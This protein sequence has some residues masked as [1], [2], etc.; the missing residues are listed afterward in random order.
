[1]RRRPRR[2]LGRGR[3]DLSPERREGRSRGEA[4]RGHGRVSGGAGRR[5]R[6]RAGDRP[7]ARGE[8][9][10]RSRGRRDGDASFRGNP[11]DRCYHC[12]TAILSKL[13]AIAQALGFPCI[14]EASNKDD[15]RDLSARAPGGEGARREEPAHRGRAHEGGYPGALEGARA[16]D[17]EQAV[18][19]LSR[20]A[21]SV[22][23]SDH[24]REARP[25][26]SGGRRISPRSAL[27]RAACAITA[28]LA[29]IEVPE[30]EIARLDR[31]GR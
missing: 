13:L 4:A 3:F 1:M 29:R 14:L 18:S 22:R 2:V 31:R 9:P 15:V 26:S 8:A 23:G 11:P 6:E 28:T 20:L 25:A 30:G 27:A 21:D 5:D 12:K 19:R 24:E 10:R 16:P 7:R 17:V